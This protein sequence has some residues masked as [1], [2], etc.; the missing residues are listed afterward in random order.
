LLGFWALQAFYFCG[1]TYF[2]KY[3]FVKTMLASF[4][5]YIF[6]I[7]F[8]VLCFKDMDGDFV[9]VNYF[10]KNPVY[11]FGYYYSAFIVCF[12]KYL[13]APILYAISYFHIKEKEA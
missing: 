3:A 5:I 10:D 4:V 8:C 2:Q 12:Y 1:S 7:V 13:L 11:D 9:F 6:L